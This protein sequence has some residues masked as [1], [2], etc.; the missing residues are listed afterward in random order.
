MFYLNE[1]HIKFNLFYSLNPSFF[2]KDSVFFT[3]DLPTSCFRLF[4][5][6]CFNQILSMNSLFDKLKHQFKTGSMAVKLLIVN[7]GFFVMAAMVSIVFKLFS[8]NVEL[9]HFYGAPSE[10]KMLL[11]RPWTIISYMFAHDING[12]WHLLWNMMLFYFAGNFFVFKLGSKKLLSVYLA[13]GFFG[14]LAYFFGYNFLPV[15]AN[16]GSGVLI[17]ASAAVIAVFVAV[18]MTFPSHPLKFTFLANPI[19]LGYIVGAVILLDLIRLQ[20]SIGVE[21]GNS[22]GWISHLGGAAFGL[23]YAA[24]TRQGKNVLAPFEKFLDR[25][26]SFNYKTLF[27]KRTK[28]T[29]RAKKGGKSTNDKPTSPPKNKKDTEMI[30]SIL[31]KVKKSGY[32]SLTTREK[33]IFFKK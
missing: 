3:N 1:W 25:L 15:F 7:I 8:M 27:D 19:K 5:F 20:G 14:F 28:P 6:L 26:F 9:G 2:T 30:D 18:G 23:Y 11:L 22:G 12:I 29:L 13:G 33:E 4:V 21:G 17:G 10:W 31:E 32:Q 24:K 16:Q